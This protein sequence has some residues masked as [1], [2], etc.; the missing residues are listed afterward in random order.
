[1]AKEDMEDMDMEE[2]EA[3]IPEEIK[4]VREEALQNI[5]QMVEKLDP[6]KF[7]AREKIAI[8]SVM[9]EV[10]ENIVEMFAI[11]E[12]DYS[13]RSHFYDMLNYMSESAM[14]AIGM[15]KDKESMQ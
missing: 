15:L 4:K 10:C 13:E 1:M 3:S 8:V 2:F 7:G 5:K 9:S 6:E 11:L 12:F 14:S